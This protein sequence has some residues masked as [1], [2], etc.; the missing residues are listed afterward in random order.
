[1]SSDF[2]AQYLRAASLMRSIP[3]LGK[4][5]DPETLIWLGRC[6]AQ[7]EEFLGAFDVVEFRTATNR[8]A[9]SVFFPE[10]R[11]TILT[12][13]YRLVAS[14]EA[15]ASSTLA[16]SF[17]PAGSAF[18]AFAALSKTLGEA[19]TGVLVADPYIDEVFLTDFALCI[20]PGT[21]IRILSDREHLQLSLKPATARWIEQYG[22]ARPI[23]VRVTPRKKLHDRLMIVD[24]KTVWLVSQ[25]F[26]NLATRAH[27]TITRAD[28]IAEMKILAY[29]DL[30][31][32]AKPL[33]EI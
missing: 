22:T 15:K 18:D 10:A 11:R 13:L 27:A 9:S 7:I 25:S 29:A 33:G 5:D 19:N 16:G 20:K 1:M 14:L 4:F 32:E 6:Q 17:I 28:D 21:A 24:Q 30:W 23:E 12:I 2:D 3:N 8:L 31:E 26:K